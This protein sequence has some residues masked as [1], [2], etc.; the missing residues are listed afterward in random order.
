MELMIDDAFTLVSEVYRQAIREATGN[1]PKLAQA[2]REWLAVVAPDW[3]DNLPE[4]TYCFPIS[5]LSL[6]CQKRSESS[7]FMGVRDE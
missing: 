2:A 4:S 3:A 5:S 1:N 7:A 6:H